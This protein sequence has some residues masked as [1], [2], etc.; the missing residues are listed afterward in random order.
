LH[1]WNF[2]PDYCRIECNLDLRARPG[3]TAGPGGLSRANAIDFPNLLQ[4][5]KRAESWPA[6]DQEELALH[7]EAIE[8][9]YAGGYRASTEELEGIDRGLRDADAGRLA[10]DEEV[11]G[12][13]S[14]SSKM[15]VVIPTKRCVTY[16]TSAHTLRSAAQTLPGC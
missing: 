14:I 13:R 12:A 4:L 16:R 8:S 10:T 3:F 15:K 9:R 7:A 5:L 11:E 6:E 1:T 2:E